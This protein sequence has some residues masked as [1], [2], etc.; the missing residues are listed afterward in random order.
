MQ[1]SDFTI[2]TNWGDPPTTAEPQRTSTAL[3][4]A[5]DAGG[6]LDF[7]FTVNV[8][9]SAAGGHYHL[10]GEIVAA[11]PNGTGGWGVPTSGS[12]VGWNFTVLSSPPVPGSSL[13][14]YSVIVIGLL[15]TSISVRLFLYHRKSKASRPPYG[16]PPAPGMYPPPPPPPQGPNAPPGGQL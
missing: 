16:P 1:V 5:I 11:N 7:G 6:T 9:A 14:L 4:V 12:F 15:A 13:S 2:W 3:P 10:A 8:P